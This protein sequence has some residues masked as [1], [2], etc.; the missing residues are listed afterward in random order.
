MPG[1][2]ITSRE[3]HA[4]TRTHT[5]A[6]T[7]TGTQPRPIRTETD[8]QAGRQAGTKTFVNVAKYHLKEICSLAA[9]RCVTHT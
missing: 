7:H 3:L 9:A 1:M 8:N 5:H 2:L 4:H 6:H